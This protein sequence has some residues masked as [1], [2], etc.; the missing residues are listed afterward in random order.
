MSLHSFIREEHDKI[1]QVKG[2]Y[3]KSV[4]T[5]QNLKDLKIP[6]DMLVYMLPVLI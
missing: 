3:D 1:T 6:L 2:S 5:L 4:A